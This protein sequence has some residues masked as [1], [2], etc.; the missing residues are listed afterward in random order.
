[1]RKP[2]SALAHFSRTTFERLV[3]SFRRALTRDPFGTHN[4]GLV[5]FNSLDVTENHCL[6]IAILILV[7]H[8]RDGRLIVDFVFGDFVDLVAGSFD[9]G[10][11]A[12]L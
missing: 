7:E 1:M 11:V 3:G 12:V 9:R 6:D 8:G 4:F 5:D 10:F 2:S